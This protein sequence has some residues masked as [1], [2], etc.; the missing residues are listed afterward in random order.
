MTWPDRKGYN[1]A[2]RVI[3]NQIHFPDTRVIMSDRIEQRSSPRRHGSRYS[4][5]LRGILRVAVLYD[6]VAL[7]TP[8]P[9]R[10]VSA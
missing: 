3:L 10:M 5:L 7:G 9:K 1:P 2:E 6:V 4:K 8:Q